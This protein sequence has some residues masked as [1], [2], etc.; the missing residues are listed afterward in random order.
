M[1]RAKRW[2]M[3]S[4]RTRSSILKSRLTPPLFVP[5]LHPPF[6]TPS[7]NPLLTPSQL[8]MTSPPPPPITKLPPLS[9]A[10]PHSSHPH[11]PH[12]L[13]PPRSPFTQI[14]IITKST[15]IVTLLN[16]FKQTRQTA[17]CNA[18]TLRT[19][20]PV[21]SGGG[22]ANDDRGGSEGQVAREKSLVGKEDE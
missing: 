13:P 14:T 5:N 19:G 1:S 15:E 21:A 2:W 7:P 11:H 10:P 20:E 18:S 16:S 9:L 22:V 17:E 3:D 6:L 12:L 4:L 8:L